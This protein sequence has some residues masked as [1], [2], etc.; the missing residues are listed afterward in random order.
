MKSSSMKIS[1][2]IRAASR[3]TVYYHL[4]S[5]EWGVTSSFHADSLIKASA[6]ENRKRIYKRLIYTI[7]TWETQNPDVEII[8]ARRD[9]TI[10]QPEEITAI[11]LCPTTPTAEL[12]N[13]NYAK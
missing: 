7:F 13:R 8:A 9:L 11:R 6:A 4:S 10:H 2:H 5:D 3:D 12:I 1:E